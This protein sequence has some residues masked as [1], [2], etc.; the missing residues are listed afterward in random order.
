MHTREETLP[1]SACLTQ[2]H[3]KQLQPPPETCERGMSGARE[4]LLGFPAISRK[5]GGQPR[6]VNNRDNRL[7]QEVF[8]S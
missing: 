7:G 2:N 1:G 5:H 8:V 6:C 3:A 4:G